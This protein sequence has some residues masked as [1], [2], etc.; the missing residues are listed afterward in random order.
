MIR[1][2]A[3]KEMREMSRDGRVR[4]LGAIVALLTIAALVFG[5]Q[6]TERAEHDR[7]HAQDRSEAQWEG[8]GEKNPH[9]AAHYGTHIFAPTS[10]ATAIDPGVST[11][12]GR[13]IRVEAHKRNLASHSA[14]EDGGSLSRM[15]AFSVTTVLLQLVPLLIIALGY[16]LWSLE[17][18]RGTLRQ[19]LS[20]GVERQHLF[21]GKSLGMTALI[22][23]LLVPAGALVIGTL[24]ALGGGDADTALRIVLLMLAYGLY[25]GIF[26]AIT[27]TVSAKAGSSRS[28]LVLM[29]GVWVFFCLI[30]PRVSAEIG[31]R[32]APLPSEAK[33]Q[34]DIASTL[35]KGPDGTQEREEAV[36]EIIDELMA[37]QGM[38]NAGLMIDQSI[39]NGIELQAEAVW[40]DRGYDHHIHDLEEQISQQE[41]MISM[42]GWLSPTL[43][44]RT[45]SAGL[46]GTDYAHHRNFTNH[47]EDWRKEFVTYLNNAFAENAGSDGW[48]YKA[49]PEVWKN[50]PAFEYSNPPV[51]FA[52]EQHMMSV[53]ALFLWFSLTLLIAYRA[54]MSVRVV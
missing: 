21:W 19:V 14:A 4:L 20:T 36:E 12:M 22:S 15:G 32:L 41:K 2:I 18:E 35:E 11:Y 26:A 29:I 7:S 10:V 47:V 16:G 31:G 13:S 42:G 24:S 9:V 6:Q 49:D 39:L 33:L 51:R 45:L 1:I 17:R 40:E 23:A 44:M 3:T 50:S 53:I 54:S 37:E 38:E 34:R 28:A 5:I 43:A 27:I 8:Q 25:F 30:I 46:C 48:N 52:L